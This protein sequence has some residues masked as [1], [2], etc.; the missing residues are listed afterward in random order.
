MRTLLLCWQGKSSCHVAVHSEVTGSTLLSL[1]IHT[2]LTQKSHQ[3]LECLAVRAERL[4]P[5]TPG[6]EPL[7]WPHQV[8]CSAV[9]RFTVRDYPSTVPRNQICTT[10]AHR[11]ANFPLFWGTLAKLWDVC[12]YLELSQIFLCLQ[13]NSNVDDKIFHICCFCRFWLN[14]KPM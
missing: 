4:E 1:C 5:G 8:G 14:S 9:Q 2:N 7:A 12:K 11:R 6:S 10:Q 3:L 13:V